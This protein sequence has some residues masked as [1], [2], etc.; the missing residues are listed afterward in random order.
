MPLTPGA[1]LGRFEV[2]APLGR[3]GMG[4]V[5]R[6]RD[7]RLSREV[8]LK[9]LPEQLARDPEWVARFEREAR[10]LAALSHPNVAQIYEV[11]EEPGEAGEPLRFLVM[12]LV[13]GQTLR[14]RLK[15]G[16]LAADEAAAVAVQVAR[17]LAAAHARGVIHRDL[18]PANV[19]LTEDGVAKV[20]DFGLARIQPMQDAPDEAEITLAVSRPGT[21]LGTAAY[22]APEQLRGQECGPSC[23]VWAFGCCLAEMASGAR[24]FAGATV[25]EIASRVL[26][27]AA[28]LSALPVRLPA[29]LRGLVLA[30]LAE[31]PGER[32]AMDEIVRRLSDDGGRSTPGRRRMRTLLVAAAVAAA[33]VASVALVRELR[34]PSE[35][36]A[37]AMALASPV[38]RVA[39]AGP[40]V[41]AAGGAGRMASALAAALT[42]R[43]GLELVEAGPDLRLDWAVD[44]GGE[45]DRVRG[46][47]VDVDAGAT[48]EALAYEVERGAAAEAS[49]KVAESIAD[50]VERA[51]VIR[52]LDRSD[53][54]HGFLVRRSASLGVARDFQQGVALYGRRRLGEAAAAFEAALATE[55]AFWPAGV[56]LAMIDGSTSRFEEGRQ[57]L[58]ALRAA[59]HRLDA[60]EVVVFEVAQ[61]LLDDDNHRLS[62][63]LERARRRFPTSGELI[64][65]AAWTR[66]QIG[67]PEAAV[68]L[69]QGLIEAGWQPD[70]SP[71]WA[72]LALCQVLAGQPEAGLK[73][74]V[75]GERRFPRNFNLA[76]VAGVA[77]ALAGRSD[78]AREAVARAIRKRTDYAAT[79]PLALHQVAAYWCAQMDWPEERRRQL[80]LW[81]EAID[82]RL[83]AAPDDESL[84]AR[85][86]E[87]LLGL[88]RPAEV[89]AL[90]APRAAAAGDPY[91]LITLGRAAAATGD[92]D[93][94][95][96][97]LEAAGGIWRRE[98]A[99]ALGALAYN[100][101]C[102]W[103]VL[104]DRSEALAWLGRA[105]D[106]YGVDRIDLA[107]DPDL[108]ELRRAGLLEAFARRR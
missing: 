8:A 39:L 101:A 23:D 27:G 98:A 7:P 61:A 6:A 22:M 40:A 25:P 42:A 62:E 68:P 52:E 80:T 92:R 12:E 48:V 59:S 1:R 41:A 21:V 2:L 53:P 46:E 47:L 9:V 45:S 43:P 105:A 89:L 14:D 96:R 72:Q 13:G 83:A 95:R 51:G 71:T 88:G 56:Y 69:L 60:S 82:A 34:Q 75:E 85:R 64:Y 54:L 67:E 20:L 81:L 11:G 66:R 57:R 76:Y 30:C 99:P 44:E 65:R 78:A 36:P 91:L 5:W 19:M 38:L 84:V 37:P 55:P 33:V 106:Q 28:D 32:P 18:K 107:L 93:G 77:H 108:A 63:A 86:A 10:A 70:W 58:T 15:A 17:G 90:L 79:D 35:P 4:E 3:G 73:T 29:A 16:P 104:D 31:A 26:A 94:A 103:A 97:A 49:R 102:A 74:A 87:A 100:I 50:R 24:L